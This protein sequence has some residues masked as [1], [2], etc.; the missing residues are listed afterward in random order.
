MTSLNVMR[1]AAAYICYL[2]DWM[3]C[4]CSRWPWHWFTHG[5]CRNL[6]R[7]REGWTFASNKSSQ[8][9]GTSSSEQPYKNLLG[10]CSPQIALHPPGRPSSRASPSILLSYPLCFWPWMV[11]WWACGCHGGLRRTVQCQQVPINKLLP[12]VLWS[13]PVLETHESPVDG[14][15]HSI[16][17]NNRTWN[18]WLIDLTHIFRR[19]ETTKQ[20]DSFGA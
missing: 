3:V 5:R 9:A 1:G 6:V 11:R 4:T 2:R 8:G 7:W 13:P 18:A 15:K 20:I 14:S 12:E 17:P 10:C 19:V 16:F